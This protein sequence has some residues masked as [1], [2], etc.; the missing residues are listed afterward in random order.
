MSIAN[1]P[2]CPLRA[3]HIDTKGSFFLTFSFSLSRAR[4]GQCGQSV[5]EFRCCL[6]RA[7]DSVDS[8]RGEL[9]KSLEEVGSMKRSVTSARPGCPGADGGGRGLEVLGTFGRKEPPRA[10][11]EV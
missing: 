2:H 3:R 9:L 4:N 11:A 10:H 6:A 1:C 7:M 8:K 5:C